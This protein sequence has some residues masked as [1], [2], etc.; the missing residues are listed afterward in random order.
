MDPPAIQEGDENTRNLQ[1]LV[2]S[3]LAKKDTHG[4]G[5]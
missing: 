1:F 4:K 5:I 2:L 3:P